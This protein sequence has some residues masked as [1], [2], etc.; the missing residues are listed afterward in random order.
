MEGAGRAGIFQV[1]NLQKS[2]ANFSFFKKSYYYFFLKNCLC[3]F[4]AIRLYICV[5]VFA[6]L[7]F[8]NSK[9]K[10]LLRI[11]FF[12]FYWIGFQKLKKSFF[13]NFHTFSLSLKNVQQLYKPILL[14]CKNHTL[15]VLCQYRSERILLIFLF[16]ASIFEIL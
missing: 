2:W 10:M 16:F 12:R 14:W 6:Q 4:A 13:S 9:L 3:V 1:G 5:W 15:F 7:H 8:Y 11:S